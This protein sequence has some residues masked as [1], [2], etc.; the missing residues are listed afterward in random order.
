MATRTSSLAG[1]RSERA[2]P[3]KPESSV[4]HV[5]TYHDIV[6]LRHRGNAN[7]RN[8]NNRGD[9]PQEVRM[10]HAITTKAISRA[11]CRVVC[12]LVVA[13]A[14]FLVALPG[15]ARA[16]SIR[17]SCA[18]YATNTYDPIGQA[19]HQHRQFGNTSLTNQST[20]NSLYANKDTSCAGDD[21]EW[22]TNAGW[23]P[24]ERYESVPNAIV[25]YRGPG[26][27]DSRIVN[28]PRGM[29]LIGKN[30]DYAS[31]AEVSYNCGAS[32]GDAAPT[33]A[34][35]PY[36]CKTNWSTQV[37]FPRCW[38]GIGI[39]HTDVVYGPNRNSCPLTHPYK[40][41]EINYLMRHPN[42]DGVVP[43]PLQVS[44]DNGTWH[45]YT[46]MHADYFFAAQDEFQ[47][48][49]DLNGDGRIQ[50]NAGTPA[51]DGGY[52]ESSL[53]DL[54]IKKAPDSLEYNNARC[55][56]GG[57]LSWHKTALNNYYN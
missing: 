3:A 8:D 46:S 18:I 48:A 53:M 54:C 26:D 10:Q 12:A 24:V 47:R 5:R 57:L 6:P 51:Y 21:G 15:E 42:A 1:P 27:S 13:L 2:Y 36:D 29:E 33:Q 52:S 19:S 39:E 14:A 20:G 41:P 17:A 40:L 32:P 38:D 49:V 55:R 45:P 25:Y 11:T 43:K 44:G 28:I 7:K 31:G 23:F 56:T 35:P 50:D 9:L 30:V 4:G 16:D 34:T 37:R 22:W